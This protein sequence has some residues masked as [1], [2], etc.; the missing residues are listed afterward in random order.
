[1]LK[2]DAGKTFFP[3]LWIVV[4]MV[5]AVAAL[6]AVVPA[7]SGRVGNAVMAAAPAKSEAANPATHARLN[8]AFAALPLAFEANQGQVDP[9]VKYVARGNG[10]KLYLTSGDAVLSFASHSIKGVSRPRQIMEQRVLGYSRKTKRLIRRHAAQ[11]RA[12]SPA[13]ASL[14]MHLL[15]SDPKAKIEGQDPLSAKVNYFIG[16]DPR[17]WHVGVNEFARVSYRNVY[18]GVDMTY[19]GQHEQLEFDFIVAPNASLAP[20]GLSF[21]GCQHMTTDDSGNLVLALPVGNLTLHKPVAYQ[22]RD[23]VRQP[24]D[25][26]FVL[27]ARNQVGFEIGAYDRSRELVIDPSLSYATYIGGDTDDEGYGIAVDN[28]GN[29]YVTGESDSASG[30]PGGNPPS[31]GADYDSFVV[32]IKADG[33]LGYTTFVGGSGDDLGSGI[34]VN[35]TTGAVYVGGITTSTD[36]P[37]TTGAPQSTSGSPAGMD[38]V[39]GNST[40][41]AP[42]TDAFVFELSPT[43]AVV[44]VT[45][46]GGNNDDGAFAVALDGSGNAYVTGFTYSSNFPLQSAL[47]AILNNNVLSSPPFGDAFV[48]EVNPTGTALVYS[49]YLGGEND[50]F[51]SGIAVDSSGNAFVTGSTA[52]VDFPFTTGAYQTACGTDGLCNAGS[53]L[54]FSDVF[55]TELAAGGGSLSY[56]TYLGGSSDD[57]GLAIALDGSG[58]IYVTGQTTD[59]NTNVGDFPIV[60]GFETMYGNNNNTAS[61]NAFVSELAPLGNGTSDLL[62][63]SYL[64]GSTADVGLGIAVDS[65]GNAYVTGS[66]LSTDFPSGGGFQT[67]LN[68][69]S[70][71]FVTEVAAGGA[72]LAYS[73]YLGGPGDENFD[74]MNSA[75]LG[76]EVAFGP[77]PS[78][79]LF[80]AGT[81]SA[82]GF[83]VTSGALQTTFGGAPFDAFAAIVPPDFTISA[84]TP[85]AVSPGSS[86][87]STV[88]LT[89]TNN[90]T[91]K[92]NLTCSVTGSGS[93][94]P[95]CSATSFSPA[96]P[97]TPTASGAT[98]AL[99]ITTT[100]ASGALF[101]PRQFF[102]AMWL[103]IA[104]L[105]LAGMGFS[106]ARSRRK[107]LLGFLMI[108]MVMTA[109]FLMPAC[110]GGSSSTPP[111]VT[112][113]GCT[114]A[115]S[116]TV[117]ITGTGTDTNTTKHAT[118]VTLTVN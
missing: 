87:S 12:I 103:P 49:T 89:S 40:T 91:S 48:A 13:V 81:T 34:A 57:E 51:G 86:G 41:P 59:D 92:V 105:S 112:C 6:M 22:Q 10:Y 18:P 60:G 32:K 31:A 76:G 69:N 58:N 50:D 97:I 66:T 65:V 96:S 75:F 56:S 63:S 14:R 67:S 95:S 29:S 16:N 118:T 68:G 52:S 108:G 101:R 3:A 8:A 113:T 45:Y 117:T 88:I 38:C 54:I 19:H 102:Y 28:A 71:A 20:I 61:S 93:P 15:N 98:S 78:N 82:T 90:Y 74:S 64:G 114:P 70:D 39:T 84:S 37:T 99:T 80:I 83:P 106:S 27:K 25:A 85:A 72:S 17:R 44:Y 2:P 43:G 26:R 104:G 47:Y 73:S 107:R 109:L 11:N 35:G 46:L 53:G 115:G 5:I 79:Q 77:A 100:G 116:Y 55:V 110:G 7:K 94:L 21:A 24:V 33:T 62:Y 4:V 111:P 1:L 9:Q 42:C 36:L 23:G 30:F